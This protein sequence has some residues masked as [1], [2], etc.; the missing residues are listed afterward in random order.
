M[1]ESQT[2]TEEVDAIWAPSI[3]SGDLGEHLAAAWRRILYRGPSAARLRLWKGRNHGGAPVGMT[4]AK[5]MPAA[6]MLIAE[7]RRACDWVLLSSG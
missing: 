6:D 7:C 3:A 1:A 4:G 2:N 5:M